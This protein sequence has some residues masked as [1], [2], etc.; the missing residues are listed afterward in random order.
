MPSFSVP[1]APIAARKADL[2]VTAKVKT[3]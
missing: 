1:G 2:T 3:I